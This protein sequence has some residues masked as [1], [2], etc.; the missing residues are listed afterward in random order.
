MKGR[1][2]PKLSAVLNDPHAREQLKSRLLKGVNGR[3]E[4]EKQSFVLKID[5]TIPREPGPAKS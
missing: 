5:N 3:I 4:T 2:S 1:I